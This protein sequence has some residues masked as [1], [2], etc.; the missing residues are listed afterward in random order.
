[1]LAFMASD[2]GPQA[3]AGTPLPAGIASSYEVLVGDPANPTQPT[4]AYVMLA[5]AT[6]PKPAFNASNGYVRYLRD[7]NADMFAYSQSS[8]GDY[9]ASPKCPYCVPA[10]GQLVLDAIGNPNIGLRMPYDCVWGQEPSYW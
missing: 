9:G 2:A 7:P 6:G 10:T 3:P 4:F 8:Y 5:S 1:E